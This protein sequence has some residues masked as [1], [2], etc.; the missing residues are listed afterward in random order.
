MSPVNKLGSRRILF[1]AIAEGI[2]PMNDSLC[3]TSTPD[4]GPPGGVNLFCQGPENAN[5]IVTDFS[6]RPC[7]SADYC[8]T[9]GK[10]FNWEEEYGDPHFN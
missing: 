8:P 3:K 9:T 4:S 10:E 6:W 1:T 5:T 7:K 2:I